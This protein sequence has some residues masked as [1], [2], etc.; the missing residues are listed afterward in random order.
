MKYDDYDWDELP[1]EAK[2]AAEVLGYTKEKWDNEEAPDCENS[3]WEEL[4]AEQKEAAAVLGYDQAGW[5][6]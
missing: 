1:A 3:A 2:A 5:D 4:T 6:A